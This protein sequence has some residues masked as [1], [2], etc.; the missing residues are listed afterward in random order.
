MEIVCGDNEIIRFQFSTNMLSPK[1]LFCD[2]AIIVVRFIGNN[3]CFSCNNVHET[4]L[5]IAFLIKG[6]TN[7]MMEVLHAFN[8]LFFIFIPQIDFLLKWWLY[9]CYSSTEN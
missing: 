5:K 3:I 8:V 6:E 9:N 1:F 7:S 2:D 4:T